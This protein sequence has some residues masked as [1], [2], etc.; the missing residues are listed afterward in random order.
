MRKPVKTTRRRLLKIGAGTALASA[1]GC[2]SLMPSKPRLERKPQTV[3]EYTALIERRQRMQKVFLE[4]KKNTFEKAK[5]LGM[6]SEIKDIEKQFRAYAKLLGKVQSAGKKIK[7]PNDFWAKTL[8]ENLA[9][10]EKIG[11]NIQ[12]S[13]FILNESMVG[14]H[15]K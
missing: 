3:Q 11:R 1:A 14:K 6:K 9:A 7:N 5:K 2:S 12:N 13:L 8:D 4:R 10:L 15:P